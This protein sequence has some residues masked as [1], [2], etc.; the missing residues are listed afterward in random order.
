MYPTKIS[1]LEAG[2]GIFG[3][4]LNESLMILL[5]E[6]LIIASLLNNLQFWE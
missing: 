2:F 1:N 4:I 3:L 5:G 6:K